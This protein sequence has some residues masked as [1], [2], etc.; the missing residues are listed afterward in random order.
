[1]LPEKNTA[2]IRAWASRHISYAGRLVLVNTVLFGMFNFWAQVFILL[3]DVVNQ[4]MKLCRNF[5]W[6]GNE[7]YQKTL[8]VAWE[9]LCTHRK[10]GGLGIKNLQDWNMACIAKLVWATAQKKDTLWVQW[11]HRRYLKGTHWWEYTPKSDTSWYWQKLQNVKNRFRDYPR[12]VYRVTE[13]Y[14]WLLQETKKPKWAKL[15]WSRTCIPRH[16]FTMWLFMQSRL[17]VL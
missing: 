17:P 8:Y 16:S 4:V 9:K 10:Q 3:Q 14:N 7:N 5:L 12:E 1:M 11:V 13:E 6:G 15:V 2:K